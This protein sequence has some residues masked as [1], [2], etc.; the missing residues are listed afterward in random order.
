M[1]QSSRQLDVRQVARAQRGDRVAF[2]ELVGRHGGALYTLAVASTPA[3]VD[4]DDLVQD[5]FLVAWRDLA[6][7]ADASRFQPWLTGILRRRAARLLRDR[8]RDRRRLMGRATRFGGPESLDGS[9][10]TSGALRSE[11]PDRSSGELAVE[12]QEAADVVRRAIGSLP[13]DLRLPLVLFYYEGESTE[14][15]ASRL[16]Q[17]PAAIRKRLERARRRLRER[18]PT[19]TPAIAALR[20]SPDLTA[21]VLAKLPPVSPPVPSSSSVAPASV[22]ATFVGGLIVTLKS[23]ATLGI[24]LAALALLS[25]IFV[26][27]LLVTIDEPMDVSRASTE[28]ALH[29]RSVDASLGSPVETSSSELASASTL[30]PR[31]T[32]ASKSASAVWTL[33]IVSRASGKPLA[34]T[35]VEARPVEGDHGAQRRESDQEGRIVFEAMPQVPWHFRALSTDTVLVGVEDSLTARPASGGTATLAVEVRYRL[36]G[37]LI[38]EH[39]SQPV[40]D[41]SLIA[42]HETAGLVGLA[43]T[44]AEGRFRAQ[45]SL[46]P[47]HAILKTFIKSGLLEPPTDQYLE[48]GRVLVGAEPADDV[49]LVHP[50]SGVLEGR[51]ADPLDRPVAGARVAVVLA[52]SPYISRKRRVSVQ[53]T[54]TTESDGEGRFRFVRLPLKPVV[55]FGSSPGHSARLTNPISF[56]SEGRAQV[57]IVLEPATALRGRAILPDG[58]PAVGARISAYNAPVSSPESV[59]ADEQG[60]FV[61]EDIAPESY[62]V[63]AQLKAY[64]PVHLRDVEVGAEGLEEIEIRFQEPGLSITGRVVN[65]LGEPVR[66]AHVSAQ[67]NGAEPGPGLSRTAFADGEGK[68]DL[69]GL[70]PGSWALAVSGDGFAQSESSVFQAGSTDVELRTPV[71]QVTLRIH[72]TSFRDDEAVAHADAFIQGGLSTSFGRVDGQGVREMAVVPGEYAIVTGAPGHAPQRTQ[73]EVRPE[74]RGTRE[75]QVRL[76]AGTRVSGRV[77]DAE[78][79]PVEGVTVCVVSGSWLLRSTA[80]ATDADGR[81]TIEAL[82]VT[83]GRLGIAPPGQLHP[84]SAVDVV[85]DVEPVLIVR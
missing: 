19:W 6:K 51:V 12:R 68:F 24:V 2:G 27:D 85:R 33:T 45:R 71:A 18:L 60:R 80:I 9:R 62:T 40:P 64:E 28:T 46:P 13:I 50:W 61:F 3:T 63:T 22:G 17:S 53:Q 29:P 83:G 30:E 54:L 37:R 11:S 72:V 81:F 43:S 52:S 70:T 31:A 82:P 36:S 76:D 48:V 65:D 39:T 14:A 41:A 77:V 84:S 55:L 58:S 21:R 59:E 79:S 49:T 35:P 42:E 78:Q 44:D 5:V 57:A 73:V 38:T 4:A 26:D 47:G 74:D 8:R 75:V 1:S 15:V 23:T 69:F 20:P 32:A 67:P 56:D 25:W 10:S 34:N 66:H 7:L 16:G